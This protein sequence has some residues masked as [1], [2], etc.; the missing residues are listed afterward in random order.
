[1]K[2]KGVE[3]STSARK[4]ELDVI[5]KKLAIEIDQ[6]ARDRAWWDLGIYK[7]LGYPSGTSLGTI[8]RAGLITGTALGNLINKA[9]QY[10]PEADLGAPA[11]ARK[12]VF[13][14]K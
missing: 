5:A 10:V 14:G 4:A 13:G 1:M 8:D 3:E 12:D 9:R 11:W 7:T 6:A 2:K